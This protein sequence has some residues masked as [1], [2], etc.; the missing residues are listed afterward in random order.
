M[1]EKAFVRGIL[2]APRDQALRLVFADW[3]EERGDPRGEYVGL[4][5]A[6]RAT[7]A[8]AARLAELR[9]VIA[10]GWLPLLDRPP[11]KEQGW[12]LDSAPESLGSGA[13]SIAAMLDWLAG[14]GAAEEMFTL[15]LSYEEGHEFDDG[16]YALH[17]GVFVSGDLACL[18]FEDYDGLSDDC[19]R[20]GVSSGH[21]NLDHW[22]SRR[23]GPPP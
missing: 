22:R 11:R 6:R 12:K 17:L 16:A 18:E 7:R 2:D 10:P 21:H 14:P 4:R 15:D 3:L 23:P 20:D 1:D 13:K 8:T 5:A 19:P 9:A